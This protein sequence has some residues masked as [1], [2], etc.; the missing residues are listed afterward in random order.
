M[1]SRLHKIFQNLAIGFVSFMPNISNSALLSFRYVRTLYVGSA[2]TKYSFSYRSCLTLSLS[3]SAKIS[4][5]N[6][7]NVAQPCH[8][9]E[10]LT[11][12]T[13]SH[14]TQGIYGIRPTIIQDFFFFYLLSVCTSSYFQDALPVLFVFSTV[15]TCFVHLS[16]NIDLYI[17]RFGSGNPFAENSSDQFLYMILT[18]TR[19]LV[20]SQ[21]V[22]FHQALSF[23]P[24]AVKCKRYLELL[25]WTLEESP[26]IRKDGLSSTETCPALAIQSGAFN[27]ELDFVA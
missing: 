11:R 10:E 4:V 3:L 9:Y 2:G 15:C 14:V 26:A 25:K 16:S 13:A 24:A 17:P 23:T 19:S 8:C 21:C 18:L 22:Q 7:I 5:A 6:V 12:C 27:V 20:A 1:C